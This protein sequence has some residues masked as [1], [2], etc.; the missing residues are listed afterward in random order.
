MPFDNKGWTQFRPQQYTLHI[1][2]F[3]IFA[4]RCGLDLDQQGSHIL[5]KVQALRHPEAIG[6][7]LRG[8]GGSTQGPM[9]YGLDHVSSEAGGAVSA[10]IPEQR[11]LGGYSHSDA[12]QKKGLEADNS[13]NMFGRQ[14]EGLQSCCDWT[15]SMLE[16]RRCLC[17]LSSNGSTYQ[18]RRLLVS[19]A[20]FTCNQG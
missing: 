14:G 4:Q 18:M 3:H 10:E 7:R 13:C 20:M 9:A 8:S 5:H 16:M 15:C 2:S 1:S 6:C 17:S 12:V 19:M 11:S